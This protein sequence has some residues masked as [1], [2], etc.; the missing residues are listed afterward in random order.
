ML[1]KILLVTSGLFHPPYFGRMAVHLALKSMDG[2]AFQHIS[3]LGKLPANLGDFSA[4]VLY[5]HHK[6]IP[7]AA[8]KQL[9]GFVSSGGGIL[10]IHSATASFKAAK[11]YFDILGG[12]FSGHGP[13]QDFEIVGQQTG[14]FDGVMPFRIKDEL[15]LH[16]LQPG[17]EVHYTASLQGQ[18]IPVVWTYRYG[19][20]KICYAAPGHTVESMKHPAMQEILRQGLKWTCRDDD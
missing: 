11:G 19:R 18:H 3:A 15:Y 9:E 20:G 14:I 13:V 16:E 10:A 4:M 6:T 7:D 12:R 2:F 5:F 1:R 17:I 8:L